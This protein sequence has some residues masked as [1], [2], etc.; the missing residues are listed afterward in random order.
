M[1]CAI[2]LTLI[3]LLSIGCVNS[4]AAVD[5]CGNAPTVSNGGFETGSLT[6]WTATG[7]VAIV[8]AAAHS[9]IWG[10]QVGRSS[11]PRGQHSLAQTINLPEVAAGRSTLSFWI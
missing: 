3:A 11:G 7:R 1:S 6:P 4:F 5:G 2:Y 10:A 8:S 9:G